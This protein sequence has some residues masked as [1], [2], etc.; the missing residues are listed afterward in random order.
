MSGVARPTVAGSVAAVIGVAGPMAAGFAADVTPAVARVIAVSGPATA[1]C[2][3][4][5]G[6]R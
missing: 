5:W 4:T 6:W 3:A 1:C 2:V